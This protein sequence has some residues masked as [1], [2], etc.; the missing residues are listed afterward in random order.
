MHLLPAQAAALRTAGPLTSRRQVDIVQHGETNARSTALHA[1]LLAPADV[2][3]VGALL[4]LLLW[5]RRHTRVRV[6]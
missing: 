4:R 2:T 6:L 3:L 1:A 5:H